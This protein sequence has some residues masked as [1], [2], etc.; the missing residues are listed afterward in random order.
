[1]L[2]LSKIFISDKINVYKR[3]DIMSFKIEE[4][5]NK[6]VHIMGIGG[7][8]MSGI[9]GVLHE[10]GIEVTGSDQKYSKTTD[11]LKN[12]GIKINAPQTE[13]N[14][15]DQNLLIYSAAIKED[16]PER[17]K[18]RKLGIPE[19]SRAEFLGHL[20]DNFK[21]TIGISGTHGKTSTTSMIT[22]IAMKAGL[23]PTVLLGAKVPLI[24]SNYRIGKSD[25][26]VV[27]S[28][29]F[30]RSFL[31]F[32]PSIGIILNLE[33]DHLDYYKDLDD[34]K[35]AFTSYI[36]SIRDDGFVIACADDQ[37]VMEVLERDKKHRK[38]TFG[39][40]NGD[41]RA[42]NIVI[43]DEA[44]AAFDFYEGDNFLTRIQM[45][46]PGTFNIYNAMAAMISTMLL[47]VDTEHLK[48]G[49]E[50]YNGVDKRLQDLGILKGVRYVNDYGHHPTEVR[51]TIETILNYK[52][53]RLFIVIQPL[54]YTRLHI[55]FDDF[56]KLFDSADFL[57][58]VP[59]YASRE[60]DTGLTS[61]TKL[62]KAVEKRNTVPVTDFS[63]FEDCADALIQ[64]T[65]E[66]DLVLL[67]GG[68][69]PELI[70][71]IIKEKLES[72]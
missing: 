45:P 53:K 48:S 36:T 44:K 34:I 31:S 8:M 24:N 59:V 4:F 64:N 41:Y 39:I 20:M 37:N 1:M 58:T 9:A 50:S 43:N 29:E 23:D 7:S 33:A 28:C 27:E 46:I 66:G 55:F 62:A 32:P 38:I 25:L 68:G 40:N 10:N 61:S 2:N 42:K 57:Y 19:M 56:T 11:E 30:Q 14:I 12:L 60:I 15:K 18:A 26:M 16:N 71:D 35:D 72:K 13:E 52:F 54:T 6:K 65:R 63:N 47:G 49:I 5:K 70:F 67:T 22:S 3:G 51:V 69:E 21:D 17:V